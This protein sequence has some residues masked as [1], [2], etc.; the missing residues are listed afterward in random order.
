[1]FLEAVYP[2]G[3]TE[4]CLHLTR[5]ITYN[6]FSVDQIYLKFDACICL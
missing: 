2:V 6:F 5:K 4:V 1:L 3:V